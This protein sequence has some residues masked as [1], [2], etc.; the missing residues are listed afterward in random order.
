[1]KRQDLLEK[2]EITRTHGPQSGPCDARDIARLFEVADDDEK[3][4]EKVAKALDALVDEG[5]ARSF[6]EDAQTLIGKEKVQV[7]EDEDGAAVFEL[8]EKYALLP[9]KYYALI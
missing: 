8:R 7:G 5:L 2:M 9:R 1:M 6:L 3:G 4:I